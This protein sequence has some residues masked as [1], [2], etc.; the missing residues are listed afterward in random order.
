[1]H[2][3]PQ[4]QNPKHINQWHFIN[5]RFV[6]GIQSGYRQNMRSYAQTSY[7]AIC[8]AI[9]P[10]HFSPGPDIRMLSATVAQPAEHLPYSA[11]ES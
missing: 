2:A 3:T 9:A 4:P 10:A 8:T 5:W 1:M 11:L 7:C 6:C